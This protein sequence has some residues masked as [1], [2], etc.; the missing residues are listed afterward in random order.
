M[1]PPI[2]AMIPASI[3]SCIATRERLAP[4]AVDTATSRVRRLARASN[5]LAT[6]AHAITSTNDTAPS[7]VNRNAGTW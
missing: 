4:S 6:L 2:A 3:S 7:I 1:A 5:R